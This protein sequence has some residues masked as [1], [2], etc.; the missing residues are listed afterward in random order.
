MASASSG[1]SMTSSDDSTTGGSPD[2]WT[3]GS[4]YDPSDLTPSLTTDASTVTSL[5]PA[6]GTSGSLGSSASADTDGYG[7]GSAPVKFLDCSFEEN[8]AYEDGGAMCESGLRSRLQS[9]GMMSVPVKPHA[10]LAGW[11]QAFVRS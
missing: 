2:F 5:V 9:D 1:G 6:F 7:S 8:F 4:G 10:F 11:Q 3:S